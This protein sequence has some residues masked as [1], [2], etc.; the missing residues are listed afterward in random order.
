MSLLMPE[1]FNWDNV[2]ILFSDE[3]PFPMNIVP[4]KGS[5]PKGSGMIKAYSKDKGN[6]IT[7]LA[8]ISMKYGVI[9]NQIIDKI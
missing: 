5:A 8:I 3:S 2:D 6:N 7:Y 4:N 1:L 9:A